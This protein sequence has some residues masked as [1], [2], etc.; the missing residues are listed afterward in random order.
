[1]PTHHLLNGLSG[2]LQSSTSWAQ[3]QALELIQR[4]VTQ[5]LQGLDTEE[6]Q[7]FV[8]L[9][10]QAHAALAAVESEKERVVRSFKA[11]GLA[12]LRSRIGGRDPEQYR[13]DTTYIE[14]IEQPLPW[15]RQPGSHIRTPRRSDIDYR[16]IEHVKSMSL[17]E[18]A[19][20]NFGFTS[21]LRQD[22]G[23]SLVDASKVVGP[24]GDRSLKAREFI[25]IARELDLGH[26]LQV[27]I[28]ATL[29]QQGTL[30][31]LMGVAAQALLQFDA[32]DAWRKPRP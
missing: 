29:D 13:F 30:R 2:N 4:N 3:Q 21:G 32:L 12:Q 5:A 9:Q 11:D 27:K 31:R 14:K 22:S 26:Q 16:E 20:V 18:A 25:A 8:Q 23:Y 6:Q 19:C 15:D 17:W 7:R 24:D 1:M 28:K 10:R